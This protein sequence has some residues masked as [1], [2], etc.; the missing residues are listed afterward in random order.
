MIRRKTTK[1]ILGESIHELAGKKPVDKI[2]VKEI[3]ENC[4]LSS[5]TFYHHFH[6]KYELIA[7]IYIY[8]ME[9]IFLDFCDGAETWKQALLDLV[10][11]L[12]QDRNF[13]ENALKNTIGQNS[14]SWTI[15]RKFVELVTDAVKKNGISPVDKELLFNVQ[16]YLH[17]VSYSVYEW[18]INHR[19]IP[20]EEITEYLYRAMPEKLKPV[21]V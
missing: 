21:L 11:I 4:G 10:D 14:F 2:T 7:W 20:T 18:F 3:A 16:F 6:D 12:D 15:H 19:D 13:Y 5:A 17:G 9:E 8:Q 1:E